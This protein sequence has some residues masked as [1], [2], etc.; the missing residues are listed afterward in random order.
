MMWSDSATFDDSLAWHLTV[1]GGGVKPG[2]PIATSVAAQPTL[3][4]GVLEL[5]LTA[6]RSP[7]TTSLLDI[8]GR[9]VMTVHS[10][11]N[12]VSP[13]APGVYF[14]REEPSAVSRQPLAIRKVILT[15]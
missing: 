11:A 9:K 14:V 13:L 1:G 4:R 7:L 6:Y 8:S 3:V 15:K 5:P 10:G 2:L 12:D